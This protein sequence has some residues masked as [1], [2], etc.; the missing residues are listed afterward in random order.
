MEGLRLDRLLDQPGNGRGRVRPIRHASI[1]VSNWDQGK[2]W[3]FSAA[4][5]AREAEG[6][7][8][9]FTLLAGGTARTKVVHPLDEKAH[10][11]WVLIR[12]PKEPFADSPEQ[13]ALSLDERHVLVRTLNGRRILLFDAKTG[14]SIR[15]IGEE[16]STFAVGPAGVLIGTRKGAV[17]L[18][19]LEGKELRRVAGGEGIVSRVAFSGSG[20]A[21]WVDGPPCVSGCWAR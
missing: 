15:E 6:V 13:W 16:A 21:V 1:V 11:G 18:Y 17:A 10:E 4:S 9:E 5:G 8:D 14:G 19:D 20:R 7:D 3:R 2:A 12:P